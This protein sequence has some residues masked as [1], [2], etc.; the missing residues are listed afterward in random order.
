MVAAAKISCGLNRFAEEEMERI[1]K[2]LTDYTLPI[3]V[4][5]NLDR[6]RIRKYLLAD[7]K[8]VAG[9]VFFVLPES[10]GKVFI[11]DQVKESLVEDV[12]GG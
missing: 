3:K 6:R 7:K 9:S 8:V 10:I 2:I 12:I 5:E 11:T 1:E 4:P